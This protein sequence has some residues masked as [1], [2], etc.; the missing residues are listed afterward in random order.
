M[1][2]SQKDAQRALAG[3]I[4]DAESDRLRPRYHFASPAQW[5]NDPNGTLFINGEYHLFYQLNP[6]APRWGAIHWG[7]ARSAD[8]VHWEHLPIALAPDREQTEHYC[9]SGCCVNDNGKPVIFY[10][11]I[12]GLLGLANVWR[13]AQ[14]WKAHGDAALAH[15]VRAINNP[16]VDQS[17]HN[18][19]IYDWR[20]PYIWKENTGWRMVLAGKYLGDHGGSVFMYS[21]PDLETWE[22]NGGIFKHASKGVECPNMLKFGERYVLIV[23]PYSQV[24]YAIGIIEQNRFIHARWFTLDHGRDFYATNTFMDD[25]GGYKL[26]GW[27]KVPGNGAWHGCLSL[28]RHITLTDSGDLCIVPVSNLESLRMDSIEWNASSPVTGNRL[29]IK[30][31]FPAGSPSIVGL[32]LQDDEHEYPLTV[33][34]ASGNLHVLNEN[35]KLEKFDP[36]ELLNLHIYIDHSVVEVFVNEHESLATWLRPVLVNNDAWRVRLLSSASKIEAWTLSSA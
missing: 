13:G 27:I 9:F 29:E 8:L 18:R 35:R 30:V 25:D 10:T 22:F 26:V 31:T 3:A 5:M 23:S 20:D 19:K 36:S 34:F 4:P 12:G 14:Q 28:P 6:Y 17:I 21:S 24:Q 33:D 7:H 1:N 16:F 32:T 15:W 11:S 2:R